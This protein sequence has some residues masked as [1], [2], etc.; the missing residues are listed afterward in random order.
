MNSPF[1]F[2]F[3]LL[4]LWAFPHTGGKR[5]SK[6]LLPINSS[7]SGTLSQDEVSPTLTVVLLEHCSSQLQQ[8]NL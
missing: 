4:R 1:L 8:H 2:L 5:D 6:L 3:L 7:L